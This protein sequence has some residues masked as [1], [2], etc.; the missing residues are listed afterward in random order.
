MKLQA[1]LGTNEAMSYQGV[2]VKT[3]DLVSKTRK[4]GNTLH[5]NDF[6]AE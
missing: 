3:N 5:H 4:V 2:L 6:M 1:N